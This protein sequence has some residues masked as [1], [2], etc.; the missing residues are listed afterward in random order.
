MKEMLYSTNKT[1]THPFRAA[2]TGPVLSMSS[3]ARAIT[4][5]LLVKGSL[6]SQLPLLVP[7]PGLS[8]SRKQLTVPIFHP[9]KASRV[10][11]PSAYF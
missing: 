5:A 11:A 2:S 7:C 4:N 8:L 9:G 10:A 1:T 3:T 6:V